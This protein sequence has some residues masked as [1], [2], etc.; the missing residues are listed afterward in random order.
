[1]T[2]S[3]GSMMSDLLWIAGISVFSLVWVMD[4]SLFPVPMISTSMCTPTHDC[5]GQG[6]QLWY[7]RRFDSNVTRM[8]GDS[9]L[10]R[11][12]T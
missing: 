5:P 11:L 1:M 12:A 10:V 2:S 4:T 8:S 7:Q 6:L 3:I 9:M